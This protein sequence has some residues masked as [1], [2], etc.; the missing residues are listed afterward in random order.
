MLP[1]IIC[2]LPLVSASLD[3][4]II[5]TPS[6]LILHVND[7]ILTDIRSGEG[8]DRL[9]LDL[10]NSS[11]RGLNKNTF[12]NVLETE[13]LILANNS[14]TSLPDFV[15]SNLTKLKSL[16]LA[17]NQIS[18]V[19]N[20]FIGLENLQLLDISH[21]PIKHLRRGHL[22]GLTRSVKIL[23]EDRNVLWSISTDDYV[24]T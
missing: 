17:G 21:N 8:S 14:L 22:F 6:K 3:S 15:F 19:Q 4:Q 20:L 23:F 10:S 18:N 2:L 12:D 5:A 11:L 7:G 16:S 13:S 24:E 1:F 9:E